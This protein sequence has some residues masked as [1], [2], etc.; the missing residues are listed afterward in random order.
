MTV[1]QSPVSLDDSE[2]EPRVAAA[3]R[4]FAERPFEEARAL[5][6]EAYTSERV[7]QVEL[8]EIFKTGW[9]CAG[10]VDAR[11]FCAGVRGHGSRNPGG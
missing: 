10:R 11:Q 5:P 7:L 3:L 6:P 2:L 1:M 9:L 8:E 4:A